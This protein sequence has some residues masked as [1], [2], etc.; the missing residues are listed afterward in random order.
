MPTR[1]SYAEG[2]PSWVDLATP[3]LDTAQEFYRALFGWEYEDVGSDMGPYVMASKR[4]LVAA[5]IGAAPEGQP[6]VWSTYLAVDDAQ[7]TLAKIVGAGG[8]TILDC[9]DVP[10]GRLAFAADPTGAVFGIWEAGDHFG[11]AIVNEHGSL[12]WNELTTDDLDT[13][14]PFYE[15]VFGYRMDETN[16]PGGPYW[17]L[18]VDGRGVA[19]AMAPPAPD[20]PNYW[21]IYFAVDDAHAAIETAIEAGGSKVY[22]PMEMAGV[23]TFAGVADPF[24]AH[25]TVIQLAMEVD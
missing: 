24:G 18:R 21:G 4:G 25:F 17:V 1:D 20:L 9:M 14:L 22:G 15:E 11:A 19:G 3:D 5:G 6:S 10:G 12:N 2:I 8:S 7:A 23:G 16:P 13:A